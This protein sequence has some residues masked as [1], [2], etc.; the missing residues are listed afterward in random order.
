MLT[1]KRNST[2]KDGVWLK[3]YQLYS[4]AWVQDLNRD[5][6]VPW[7]LLGILES[8]SLCFRPLLSF[9][10]DSHTSQEKVHYWKDLL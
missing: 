4:R 3:M 8:S 1:A 2:I 6:S 7:Q 9:S 10:T 5:K